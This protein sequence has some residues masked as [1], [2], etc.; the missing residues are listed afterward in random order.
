MTI[1]AE[2]LLDRVTALIDEREPT[3]RAV[4]L[5]SFAA[6]Y[7]KRETGWPN[8]AAAVLEEVC[9]AF[10]LLAN[11]GRRPASIR[12]FTPSGEDCPG[13]VVEATTDDLPYLVDSLA[14]AIQARGFVVQRV[15]H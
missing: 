7:L 6:A 15:V 1:A 5:R 8:D 12:A 13:S 3:E 4:H 9:G 2:P 10:D 14:A 11:R